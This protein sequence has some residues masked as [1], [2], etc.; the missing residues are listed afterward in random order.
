[1]T[2]FFRNCSF[3]LIIGLLF[4]S[5]QKKMHLVKGEPKYYTIDEDVDN[6]TSQN[7]EQLLTPYKEE[8]NRT[9]NDVIG[10]AAIT[11]S[12]GKPESTLGNFIADLLYEKANQYAPVKVDFAFQNYGGIRISDLAKGDITR[13]KVYELMPF[14]NLLVIV[15]CDA[16]IIE[17]MMEKMS[18]SGGWPVSKS[19]N[20]TI[21]DRKPKEY[22]I[23]GAP[24]DRSKIYH[25]AMPDYIAHGGDGSK[26]LQP[27]KKYETGKFIRDLIIEYIEEQEAPLNLKLDGRIKVEK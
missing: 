20:L 10:Q 23:G 1:M 26:Y 21:Q 4:S 12:K 18:A 14:D 9:M 17:Q 22:T 6:A 19:I 15:A 16:E 2:L 5:C 3:L 13:S 8:Y 27:L 24:L 25:V 11:L 7:I